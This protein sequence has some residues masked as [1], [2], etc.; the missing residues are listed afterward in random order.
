MA[1]RADSPIKTLVRTID[2]LSIR[3]AESEPRDKHALLLS[4]W[5]ESLL[6]FEQVWAP[7]AEHAHLIAVDLP[8]YGH[9]QGRADLYQPKAMG[10]F[11]IR[12][13]DEFELDCLHGV[14]PDI[15]VATFLFAASAHPHRFRSLVI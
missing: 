4:P 5:P 11:V 15:G 13:A 14:G 7:L 1:T 6:A 2:G 10:D 8:G 3:Y 12:L 9:S